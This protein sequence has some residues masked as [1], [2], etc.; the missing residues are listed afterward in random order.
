MER[1]VH[2]KQSNLCYIIHNSLYPATSRELGATF[3]IFDNF[4]TTFCH[5]IEQFLLNFVSQSK[6]AYL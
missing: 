6:M 1:T 4:W 5:F 3:S 2:V